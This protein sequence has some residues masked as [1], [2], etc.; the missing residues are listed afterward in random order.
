MKKYNGPNYPMGQLAEFENVI[1]EERRRNPTPATKCD[2]CFRRF[3]GAPIEEDDYDLDSGEVPEDA[4]DV[5][6]RCTDCDFTI[7][8]DCF[9]PEN[10][11][12]FWITPSLGSSF[13]C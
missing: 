1:W 6:K 7:C 3:R 8:E 4:G 12:E 11:G 10:Q 2:A 13:S 5:F 9:Q